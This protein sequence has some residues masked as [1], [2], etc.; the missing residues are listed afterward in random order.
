MTTRKNKTKVLEEMTKEISSDTFSLGKKVAKGLSYVVTAP[1][2]GLVSPKVR[3]RIYG[4][5]DSSESSNYLDWGA[6]A[7][8]AVGELIFGA[9]ALKYLGIIDDPAN[10]PVPAA[11]LIGH[12]I[13]RTLLSF[14]T[15]EKIGSLEGYLPSKVTEYFLDKYDNAKSRI[16]K[17][18]TS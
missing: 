17:M 16:G 18:E 8:S 14:M 1:A 9:G 11:V 10:Y 4:N 13:F 7:S 15:G 5:F 12:F 2:I 3:E 6:Q